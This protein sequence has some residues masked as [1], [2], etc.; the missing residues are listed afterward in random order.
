MEHLK[1]EIY[2]S[3]SSCVAEKS[4][5]ILAIR[6]CVCRCRSSCH[7]STRVSRNS[8]S[9][10][11]CKS[12][13]SSSGPPLLEL[14]C[15]LKSSLAPLQLSQPW[16]CSQPRDAKPCC[17]HT[18]PSLSIL[19]RRNYT[20]TRYPHCQ[21]SSIAPRKAEQDRIIFSFQYAFSQCQLCL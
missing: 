18:P 16:P 8:N 7:P 10:P 3:K 4:A 15:C 5:Y 14:P 17:R 13:S 12:T 20:A 11:S 9:N 1:N 2:V 6:N 19:A 21:T